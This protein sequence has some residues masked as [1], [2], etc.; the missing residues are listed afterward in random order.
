MLNRSKGRVAIKIQQGFT[1]IE[2]IIVLV[3]AAIIMLA[4][5]LVVPQLQRTQRNSRA[6]AISRQISSAAITY[7]TQQGTYPTCAAGATCTDITNI[8]GTLKSPAG[9]DYNY[10]TAAVPDAN[11]KIMIINYGACGAT[12]SAAPSITGTKFIVVI[13]QENAGSGT[14]LCQETP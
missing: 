13:F 2:V 14:T 1:I 7:R 10:V 9:T 12:P 6:Q 11:N 3:I 8:T 5:F 4:V